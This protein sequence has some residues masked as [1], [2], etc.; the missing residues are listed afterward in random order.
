MRACVLCYQNI[1]IF[2]LFFFQFILF[3]YFFHWISDF[4][5][6]YSIFNVLVMNIIFILRWM[7]TI[8]F[9]YINIYYRTI[10]T[11]I[12][13]FRWNIILKFYYI[14]LK[15]FAWRVWAVSYRIWSFSVLLFSMFLSFD[16]YCLDWWCWI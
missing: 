3:F 4:H 14:I 15:L 1:C 5:L 2:I 8:L 11:T 10:F 13:F 16:S 7:N 12:A 9:N 6:T